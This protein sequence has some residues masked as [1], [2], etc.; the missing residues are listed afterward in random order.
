MRGP[1]ARPR[2]PGAFRSPLP[3]PPERARACPPSPGR[4]IRRAL[5]VHAVAHRHGIDRSAGHETLRSD[6]GLLGIW[7]AT[8][9][10]TK[11]R[12]AW[13]RRRLAMVGVLN[14]RCGQGN[15][16]HRSASRKVQLRGEHSE[17]ENRR[18]GNG[19]EVW[20]QNRLRR[21]GLKC[22]GLTGP[23]PARRPVRASG[24]GPLSGP[25]ASPR[26][27]SRTLPSARCMRALTGLRTMQER[28]RRF[29]PG[30]RD[31]AARPEFPHVSRDQD[32]SLSSHSCQ[33]DV[34][35]ILDPVEHPSRFVAVGAQSTALRGG[36][37]LQFGSKLNE[38]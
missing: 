26:P 19:A 33:Q 5:T 38:S 11:V 1:W 13:R 27:E 35:V 15:I 16:R 21:V 4:G 8:T 36:F 2:R 12:F 20:G 3:Q 18:A 7:P 34:T 37:C 14:A 6:P 25:A 23:A 24:A 32:V 30:S 17:S 31:V 28:A 9:L 29:R 10:R 22:V